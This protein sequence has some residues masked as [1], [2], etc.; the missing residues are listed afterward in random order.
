MRN[1]HGNKRLKDGVGGTQAG[2]EA[3]PENS[4]VE[5]RGCQMNRTRGRGLHQKEKKRKNVAAD[6]LSLK[7]TVG[8]KAKPW[9]GGEGNHML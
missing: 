4:I 6:C 9:G 2:I 8:P 3:G 5:E 7:G 1:N